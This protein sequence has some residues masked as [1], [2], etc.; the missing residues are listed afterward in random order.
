M[1][2]QLNKVKDALEKHYNIFMAKETGCF[3]WHQ[4]CIET[5]E[6]FKQACAEYDKLVENGAIR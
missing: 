5:Y 6:I 3:T 4:A 2:E 1:E